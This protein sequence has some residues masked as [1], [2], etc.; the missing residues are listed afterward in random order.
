MDIFSTHLHT[1]NRGSLVSVCVCVCCL[2]ECLFFSKGPCLLFAFNGLMSLFLV[3]SVV[4]AYS[5]PQ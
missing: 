2:S 4:A 1:Y 3:I 5:S